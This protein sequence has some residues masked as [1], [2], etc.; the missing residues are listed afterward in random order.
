[1]AELHFLIG[2]HKHYKIYLKIIIKRINHWRVFSLNLKLSTLQNIIISGKIKIKINFSMFSIS[3]A[4][5]S[6]H[7]QTLLLLESQLILIYLLAN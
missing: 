3:E 2:L 1:M 6:P 7:E 5:M 4:L